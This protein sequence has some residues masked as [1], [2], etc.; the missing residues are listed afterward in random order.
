MSKG[1]C[2]CVVGWVGKYVCVRGECV[3]WGG[4]CVHG[5]VCGNGWVC[6][7][8]RYVCGWGR[9]GGEVCASKGVCGWW[10]GWGGMCVWVGRYVCPRVCVGVGVGGE[11]CVSMPHAHFSA[12]IDLIFNLQPKS[13]TEKA[14]VHIPTHASFPNQRSYAQTNAQIIQTVPA[15]SPYIASFSL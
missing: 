3:G 2:V 6:G 7:V 11:V 15:A 1:V 4:M 9:W 13:D 10:G 14:F 12:C 8:G 5:C